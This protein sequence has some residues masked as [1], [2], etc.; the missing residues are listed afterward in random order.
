M[1]TFPASQFAV[2]TVRRAGFGD[3][4]LA[5]TRYDGHA[6]LPRH[7]HENACFVVALG[8]ISLDRSAL[9]PEA[10]VKPGMVIF[11]PRHE[12][13]DNVYGASGSRCL[14]VE[15]SSAWL[16]RAGDH[17]ASLRRSTVLSGTAVA[18]LGFRM[19]RELLFD[20][21]F[22]AAESLVAC[23]VAELDRST[24]VQE[25]TPPRWLARVNDFIEAHA[26]TRLSLG[27]IAAEAGVHPVH[28]AASFQRWHGQ[29]VG[30]YLRRVRI[31]RACHALAETDA[32]LADIALGA[33]FFD[34]SH[35]GRTFKRLMRITPLRFRNA[36]RAG[37][38]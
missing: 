20:D 9:R 27:A 34:Q 30:E 33:G 37:E 8:G 5:E 35:F 26:A 17:T 18:L 22:I 2:P 32:P 29:S 14:N 36:A 16:T 1:R 4:N 11:R 23:L 15:I 10:T 13:H 21:D 7:A 31:V 38:P 3:F 25:R 6:V 12:P 19:Y 28:L 24:G